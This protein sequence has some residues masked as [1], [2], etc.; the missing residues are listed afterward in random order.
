MPLPRSFDFVERTKL[1]L[2]ASSVP[3]NFGLQMKLFFATGE[4]D[5]YDNPL[6]DVH[7]IGCYEG[8]GEEM[9]EK[10]GFFKTVAHFFGSL[11]GSIACFIINCNNTYWLF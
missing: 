11:L 8:T 10:A 2:S 1:F 3:T 4:H 6:T 7:N 9:Q 5:F